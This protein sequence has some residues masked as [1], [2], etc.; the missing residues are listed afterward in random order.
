M[1]RPTNDRLAW[2]SG[3]NNYV[4]VVFAPGHKQSGSEADLAPRL[5]SLPWPLAGSPKIH[6]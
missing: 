2:G 4:E 5:L 1:L 6:Q 3:I